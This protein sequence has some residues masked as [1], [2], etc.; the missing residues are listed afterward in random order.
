M[1]TIEQVDSLTDQADEIVG[2]IERPETLGDQ[3]VGHVGN[4]SADAASRSSMTRTAGSNG[5]L[6]CVSSFSDTMMA[7]STAVQLPSP[8]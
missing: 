1:T 5:V 8:S 7:R 2:D 4:P 6:R 3:Y